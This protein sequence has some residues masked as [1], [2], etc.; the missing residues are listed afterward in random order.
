M[1]GLIICGKFRFPRTENSRLSME[2]RERSRRFVLLGKRK[3]LELARRGHTHSVKI[4]GTIPLPGRSPNREGPLEPSP[5][6][7]ALRACGATAPGFSE[8]LKDSD[9]EMSKEAKIQTRKRRGS[10]NG[11][12]HHHHQPPH[13]HD[14]PDDDF[15]DLG[16]PSQRA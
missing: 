6:G 14:E 11:G 1:R 15:M 10:W 2:N 7:R 4:E 16:A 5:W 13:R 12:H 9:L 3:N 8:T